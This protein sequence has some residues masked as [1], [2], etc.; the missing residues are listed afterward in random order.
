[1]LAL[2]RQNVEAEILVCLSRARS[3]V[4][5]ALCARNH[6]GACISP[7][8]YR[9]TTIAPSGHT[10]RSCSARS[11]LDVSNRRRFPTVSIV[12]RIV[13]F[14]VFHCSCTSGFSLACARPC[15]VIGVDWPL[16]IDCI[17][18][19]KFL[20]RP[21]AVATVCRRGRRRKGVRAAAT[22]N[23]HTQEEIRRRPGAPPVPE[24]GS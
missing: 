22:T 8:F 3:L 4:L 18:S 2:F 14:V 12:L 20:E 23:K 10:R 5:R 24:R 6:V 9:R 21:V 13:I 15:I 16:Q 7:A 1:M 17:F 19:K 11:Q